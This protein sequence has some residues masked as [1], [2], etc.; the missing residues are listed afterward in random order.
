MNAAD[1]AKAL[2]DIDRLSVI[3]KA[4]S[5]GLTISPSQIGTAPHERFPGLEHAQDPIRSIIG[6][7]VRAAELL[8]LKW[9]GDLSYF[10]AEMLRVF[11]EAARLATD[12]A[13]TGAPEIT[14]TH[15]LAAMVSDPDGRRRSRWSGPRFA[16]L[17]PSG[18]I[19]H[20][21]VRPAGAP[22]APP[23]IS[24]V[25]MRWDAVDII[26]TAANLRGLYL[27]EPI[28]LGLALL[29]AACLFSPPGQLAILE[30]IGDDG[31][32]R[33]RA[34]AHSVFEDY[35]KER[36]PK[37]LRGEAQSLLKQIDAAPPYATPRSPRAGYASDRVDLA[38]I[39]GGIARDARA[40]ADLILLEA[41]APP[42]AIGVFGSWGSG[43]STLLAAL[44]EEIRQQ[45]A[46]ERDRI[47][48]GADDGDEATRRVGGV[49]QIELNAWS[50]ADSAN[51]W[52]SLTSDIFEQIAAGGKDQAKSAA[53]AKLVAEV[54]E[55]T[56]KEAAVL[57]DAQAQRHIAELQRDA[58]IRAA[59]EATRDAGLTAF[60]AAL[61]VLVDMFAE[62]KDKDEKKESGKGDTP[63]TL[64]AADDKAK[65][66]LELFRDAAL[67]NDGEDPGDKI[68]KYLAAANPATRLARTA[69]DYA[70]GRGLG[71]SA[72]WLLGVF[73]LGGLAFLL[74]KA[75]LYPIALPWIRA[76]I[77]VLAGAG[78]FAWGISKLAAPAI[79]GA[80][81]VAEKFKEK[82]K[83]ASERLLGASR[84][85]KAAE[86]AIAEASAAEARS[87]EYIEKY[88]E[89]QGPGASPA[90]MLGYLLEDSAEIDLLRGSLGTLATVRKAFERL[91]MLVEE[92]K[93]DRKAA[94]QR[95][96]ITIDD[97]DRCS[98]RQV[99]EI[100][101]AIHLLLA[102]PCFV[103]VAAVDARWLETA[104]ATEY[105]Q[106][107]PEGRTGS[108][109]AD[110]DETAVTPADY[111]EKIFQIAYWVR[112]LR[113]D[114]RAID[115]GSYGR[116]IDELT[117]APAEQTPP[118]PAPNLEIL[119]AGPGSLPIPNIL[120]PIEPF[121]PERPPAPERERLR[122]SDDERELFKKLGP[123]AARSPRAVKRMINVY[124]LIRVAS[125]T[126]DG[127]LVVIGPDNERVLALLVQFALACEAGFPA[128]NFETL[129]QKIEK[130]TTFD[131]GRW[132]TTIDDRLSQPT[133][134]TDK[135][136]PEKID[137]DLFFDA[138]RE[139]ERLL[140]GDIEKRDLQAAFALAGRYSFRKPSPPLPEGDD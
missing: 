131:W 72:L 126:I 111:L 99:V 7:S 62:P 44:K 54:A 96:I 114:G 119:E 65:T 29:F 63:T 60:D 73:A 59:D 97:L 133:P 64:A 12:T 89:G 140:H 20:L 23:D 88:G 91:N 85:Q 40:L 47:T 28:A 36:D 86:K 115:G 45:A 48:A 113:A 35:A 135:L 124:R 105:K 125:E 14:A 3:S 121:A 4:Y 66:P 102:F 56:H 120:T 100:L 70:R 110:T 98:E 137:F 15:L 76:G 18:H 16:L 138:L 75:V 69:W 10:D 31:F 101:Q 84:D 6:K 127:K 81:L 13:G 78:T 24:A 52:A 82:K 33:Y 136:L 22:T 104:L 26:V 8:D 87:K 51:L 94:V 112:P 9:R 53:G 130:L 107:K 134:S 67:L 38:A 42:L 118:P 19:Y 132:R 25:V 50:F 106:L 117:G 122:F 68:R 34:F 83:S 123:L 77:A 37:R 90:L 27:D 11:A 30:V 108:T 5:L 103:V 95:I 71:K 21:P 49:L 79:R 61:A 43:K 80:A 57:R 129:A 17:D 58:A 109:G 32:G 139:T 128:K 1:I 46:E 41:A 116:M 92:Q 2:G 39:D 74:V 93:G 55:R